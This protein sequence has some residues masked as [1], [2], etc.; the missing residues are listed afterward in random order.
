METN[1]ASNP[2]ARFGRQVVAVVRAI[3]GG[4]LV[5]LATVALPASAGAHPHVFVDAQARMH[6]DEGGKLVSVENIWKFD[7]AFSQYALQG[8]DA[9]GD[10]SYTKE[11]LAS[12]AEINV[13]SLKD[14]EFFSYLTIGDDRVSLLPPEKYWLEYQ[15]DR[16]TLFYTLPVE[17]PQPISQHAMLEIFD[18]EYFVE[19]GFPKEHG[20]VLD[21]APSCS[22]RH[23]SPESID[24][25]TMAVLGSLP[26]EQR[27]L[28]SDLVQAVSALANYFAITCR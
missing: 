9:N 15:G 10:G 7:A 3:T 21:G 26:Q 16:L 2:I 25:A 8:M 6:F 23:H 28:P 1:L 11:E 18:R 24:P 27:E 20:I 12:L 19:F 5:A 4:G 17:Q 13:T 22:A 14:F